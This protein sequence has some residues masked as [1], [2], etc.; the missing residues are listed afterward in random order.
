[1]LDADKFEILLIQQ[2]KTKQAWADYL[3]INISTLY[4]K[5]S[6]DN[7]MEFDRVEIIKTMELFGMDNMNDYFFNHKV[8]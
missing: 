8:P 4:R 6:P 5:L 3:G 2:K 7:S 1:M